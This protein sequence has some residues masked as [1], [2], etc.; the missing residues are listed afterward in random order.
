MARSGQ[1]MFQ[2]LP[3]INHAATM[4]KFRYY[5]GVYNQQVQLENEAIEAY[6]QSVKETI[7]TELSKTKKVFI[8]LFYKKH[9]GVTSSR[10]YN[11]LVDEFAFV[12][13]NFIPKK[14]IQTIKPGLSHELF[15]ALMYEYN[16]QI[17]QIERLR[18]K[19]KLNATQ[20]LPKLKIHPGEI[21]ARLRNDHIN[22]PISP[23]TI[24]NHRLRF[25]EAG[26]FT[27]YEFH[28]SR[29]PVD[30]VVNNAILTFF[31]PETP[32]TSQAENQLLI[33]GRWKILPHN[34]VSTRAS[35]KEK[36][37]KANV[38]KHLADAEVDNNKNIY[39]STK[40]QDGKNLTP[41]GR[42]S[43]KL[44]ESISEIWEFATDLAAGKYYDY[45]GLSVRQWRYEL[46]Q[47][48][49]S[50]EETRILFIQDF[51]KIAS[52]IYLHNP[53]PPSAGGWYKAI[54]YWYDNK[55]ITFAGVPFDKGNIIDKV[56]EYRWRINYAIRF[57]KRR[58]WEGVHY[59]AKYFDP[60]HNQPE[61]VCFAYTKKLYEK[62]EAAKARHKNQRKK[63]QL[64]SK[65]HALNL[66]KIKN[67]ARKYVTNKITLVQA[68]D[69]ISQNFDKQYLTV[70]EQRVKILINNP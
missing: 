68:Y 22:L 35:N 28:S 14:R 61:H 60:I 6:N 20:P 69:Y 56:P 21:T 55:L 65:S 40:L 51:F 29:R 42:A 23:K 47:G 49:L 39:K 46:Q 58:K 33:G 11:I 63:L 37:K 12:H 27:D 38:N 34:N 2:A 26:I 57:F 10:E 64:Q 62:N 48:T 18:K 70:F 1:T 54:K 9:R 16:V 53:Q 24:Y 13:G 52:K 15:S 41:A 66:R 3:K 19:S 59:P 50:D 17:S 4:E 30:V 44:R 45:T 32:E 36:V 5:V 25:Q 43:D 7:A 31:E 8:D 67:L